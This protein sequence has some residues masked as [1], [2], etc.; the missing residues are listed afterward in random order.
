MCYN[1]C[2]NLVEKIMGCIYLK[3]SKND[4]FF[5]PYSLDIIQVCHN[6]DYCESIFIIYK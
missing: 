4:S 6:R 1:A 3:L 5:F 2:K